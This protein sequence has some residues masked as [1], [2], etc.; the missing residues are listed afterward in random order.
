MDSS[1]AALATRCFPNV[2]QSSALTDRYLEA[3]VRQ[4]TSKS[5]AA[6]LSHYEVTW[7][8]FLPTTT[9][10]VVRYIA[11][12]ADQLALSTLKQRLAALAN[13]HQSNGF[14]APTKAPRSGSC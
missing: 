14:P 4:N 2:A 12:Y 5:Y 7:G 1:V 8:G 3:S 6:T 10:S 11:E 13:W 9:E